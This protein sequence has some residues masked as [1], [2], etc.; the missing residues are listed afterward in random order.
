MSVL[1]NPADGAAQGARD[2]IVALLGLLGEADPIGGYRLRRVIA[3]ERPPNAG[4]DRRPDDPV[5]CR[6]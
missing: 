2:Y 1:T 6:A 4:G 5:V 3:E